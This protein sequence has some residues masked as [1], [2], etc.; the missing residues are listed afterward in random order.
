MYMPVFVQFNRN[1][2]MLRAIRLCLRG[3]KLTSAIGWRRWKNERFASN[4]EHTTPT[5]HSPLP[6][7]PEL[8]THPL[9][10]QRTYNIQY[11]SAVVV[12]L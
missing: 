9:Y 1:S 10:L 3:R 12:S 5:P 7:Q 11:C 4:R 8:P 6:I 2:A